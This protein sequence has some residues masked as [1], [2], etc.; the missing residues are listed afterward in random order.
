MGDRRKYIVLILLLVSG[1]VT[2][3]FY[4]RSARAVE[5]GLPIS[6]PFVKAGWQGTPYFV[7]ESIT[8]GSELSREY[9]FNSGMPLNFLVL[10][11]KNASH[12]PAVCYTGLGWQLTDT[13]LLSSSSGKIVMAGL[14]GRMR[15]EEIL[16]YSGYLI[17]ARVIPDGIERKLYESLDRVTHG[18]DRQVFIEVTTVVPQG[19][20]KR[21]EAYLRKFLEDVEENL[22]IPESS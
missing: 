5:P 12:D 13:P 2:N 21:A 20:I 6:V 15:N 1:L 7:S 3:Y 19:E 18:Y 14:R 9:R 16:I 22:I 8:R 17:G 11:K 4:N 10:L